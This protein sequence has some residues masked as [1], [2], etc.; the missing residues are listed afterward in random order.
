MSD[1]GSVVLRPAVEADV[2]AIFAVEEASFS[3]P[4]ERFGLRRVRHLTVSP[5]PA[6]IVAAAPAGLLGWAAGF[7]WLRGKLPWG[8]VYAIAV[9]PK[10]R[11][12]RLGQRLMEAM[13]AELE[14]R[15][16]AQIF[17]E[18]RADNHPAVR[19]YQKLGFDECRKLPGYYGHGVDGIRMVRLTA[20]S[21]A[22]SP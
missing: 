5:R 16:A 14:R 7:A 18:V 12:Q 19:L 8:R 2:P 4:G 13:L 17:L 1:A 21:P 9:D 3:H 22:A 11:G 6:V 20:S 10:S 15:G